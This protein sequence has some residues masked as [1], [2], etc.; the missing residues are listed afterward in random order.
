MKAFEVFPYVWLGLVAVFGIIH[1]IWAV[2]ELRSGKARLSWR[3][4]AIIRDEEPFPYWIAVGSKF[5]ALPLAAFMFWFGLD[6]LNW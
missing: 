4:G 3:G 2:S 5:L 6:M 1:P